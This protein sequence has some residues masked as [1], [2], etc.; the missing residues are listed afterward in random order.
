VADLLVRLYALPDPAPAL[1]RVAAQGVAIRRANAWERD[2]V[3]D[4]VARTFT[5]GW[6]A[7]TAVAFGAAPC[8]CFVAVRGPALVGFACHDVAR[9][10]FFGPAGVDPATRGTGVGAALTLAVLAAMGEDGYAY[11]IIGGAGPADFYA[12]VAGAIEIPGSTP[13]VYDLSLLPRSL[14]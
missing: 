13:G 6:A 7:E 1:A 3:V 8:R 12:R 4:W 11:A 14:T 2:V 10:N 9:R 5:A